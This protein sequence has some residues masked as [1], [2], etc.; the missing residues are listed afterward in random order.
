MSATASVGVGRALLRLYPEP[1]RMRY[2][3]EMTALLEDDPPGTWS[4]A[5]LVLGAARAHLRPEP[6]LRASAGRETLMRLAVSGMFAAWIAISL[7]G[8]GFQKDTEGPSFVQAA[9]RHPLLGLGYDLV[10]AGAC[11]GAISVTLGGL[12]LLW[13]ALIAVK[14]RRDSRLTLLIALP[15]IAAATLVAVT[16]MLAA[17]A[18]S[19][20]GGF[21]AAFVL[22]ILTPWTIAIYISALVC[23]LVPGAVL[24][25]IDPSPRALR[26]ACLAGLALAAAMGLVASGIVLYTVSLW[27]TAPQLVTQQTG[28]YGA[29]TGLML[30]L[31]AGSAALLA[32]AGSSAAS[33]GRRAAYPART[34]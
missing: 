17:F 16:L 21:P 26:R 27:V 6:A 19:R 34:A 22:E 20:H 12:P 11:V 32:L 24:R 31:Q 15:A 33:R 2:R 3:D 8:I 4:L 28:P 9:A 29:G 5:T 7:A 25:R 14:A 1:W 13:Q 30:I 23:A 18:P 10:V